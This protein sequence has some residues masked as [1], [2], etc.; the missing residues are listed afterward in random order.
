MKKLAML[1][2]VA[3]AVTGGPVDD[4]EAKKTPPTPTTSCGDHIDIGVRRFVLFAYGSRK[5]LVCWGDA[6]VR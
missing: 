2:L 1:T 6:G 5:P 4:A 3:F